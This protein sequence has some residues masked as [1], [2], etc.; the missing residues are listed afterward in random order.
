MVK[1]F[2]QKLIVG[3]LL[4]YGAKLA[5]CC[6]CDRFLSCHWTEFIGVVAAAAVVSGIA[7][8]VA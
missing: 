3:G 4:L 2:P 8:T 6:P 7:L 1:N 5:I